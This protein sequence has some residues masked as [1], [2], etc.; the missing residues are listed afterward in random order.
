MIQ[1]ILLYIQQIM[2]KVNR[3]IKTRKQKSPL[4]KLDKTAYVKVAISLPSE[5]LS[6][7][8]EL[9]KE[10]KISRSKFMLTAARRWFEALKRQ[11]LVE[12]YIQGYEAVPEEAGV[13]KVLETVQTKVLDKESW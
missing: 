2:P 9:R 5:D 8:E 13:N 3:S 10:L 12:R 7:I 11:S 6:R 4:L 1:F